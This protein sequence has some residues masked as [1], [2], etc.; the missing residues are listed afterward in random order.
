M[1]TESVAR[2]L[3]VEKREHD[4]LLKEDMRER[5]EEEIKEHN[6]PEVTEEEARELIVEQRRQ[7]KHVRENMLYRANEEMNQ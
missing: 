7:T 3:I 2:K 4:R 1:D 5:A 6:I